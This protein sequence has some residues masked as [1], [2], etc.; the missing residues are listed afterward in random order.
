MP[1]FL[2]LARGRR[3]RTRRAPEFQPKEIETHIA[4]AGVLRRFA[5]S[6]WRWGHYPAGEHRDVRTAAKLRAMGTQA[7]WPDLL[8]FDPEGRLHALELKRQGNHLTD[9]QKAFA[10]WCAEHALPHA[11]A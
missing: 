7:G 5:R 1:P 4:V 10:A 9:E 3:V 6:D 8:L 2:A 11:V